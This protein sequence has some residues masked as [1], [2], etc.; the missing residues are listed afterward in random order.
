MFVFVQAQTKPLRTIKLYIVYEHGYVRARTGWTL[1]WRKE[2]KQTRTQVR[3]H[4]DVLARVQHHYLIGRAAAQVRPFCACQ[5][6]H[7]RRVFAHHK[8]LLC[9][10]DCRTAMRHNDQHCVQNSLCGS[11]WLKTYALSKLRSRSYDI[12]R[13]RCWSYCM[14][15][16]KHVHVFLFCTTSCKIALRILY[17]TAANH[18]DYG[19]LTQTT[20]IGAIFIFVIAYVS[21]SVQK[22]TVPHY[23]ADWCTAS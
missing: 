7:C 23:M 21:V 18:Q 10:H 14:P 2:R 22:P 15:L 20:D 1:A 16:Y 12:G 11:S 5:Q 9:A 13:Q 17:T 19:K 3:I 6:K 8:W 4:K